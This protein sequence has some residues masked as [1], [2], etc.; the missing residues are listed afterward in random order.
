MPVYDPRAREQFRQAALGRPAR[1]RRASCDSTALSK[2]LP[3]SASSSKLLQP[4]IGSTGATSPSL[5]GPPSPCPSKGKASKRRSSIAPSTWL[6]SHPHRLYQKLQQ[7]PTRSSNDSVFSQRTPDLKIEDHAQL[8]HEFAE[9][10]NQRRSLPDI[11]LPNDV[12]IPLRSPG[13]LPQV[14]SPPPIPEH[15]DEE[16]E[17][18]ETSLSSS[19]L[20]QSDCERLRGGSQLSIR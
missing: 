7:S 11:G 4:P 16:E 6:N 14:S 15:V 3:T 13:G 2:S 12:A 8:E 5:S 9:R 19:L 1:S 17:E 10:L 20:Q 18:E